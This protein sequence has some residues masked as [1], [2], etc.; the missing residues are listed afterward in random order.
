M[1]FLGST[2]GY[3]FG[4]F[5]DPVF[6]G[7]VTIAGSTVGNKVLTDA[8]Y[9]VEKMQYSTF[10]SDKTLQACENKA[11]EKIK[12]INVTLTRETRRIQV[13]YSATKKENIIACL[14]YI[15]DDVRNSENELFK[16][17]FEEKKEIY[18]LIE[19]EMMQK[20]SFILS[21]L[22]YKF[23]GIEALRNS[24]TT[25]QAKKI[26]PIMITKK[27]FPSPKIG[28]FFGFTLS[29]FLVIIFLLTKK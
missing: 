28:A 24:A 23:L 6:E 26:I 20:K 14:N 12:N 4:K 15:E 2:S 13:A 7:R 19:K 22:A 17:E 16:F 8:V 27:S 18:H 3:I 9:T 5:S 10:F 1:L 25:F 21:H 29:L 11:N